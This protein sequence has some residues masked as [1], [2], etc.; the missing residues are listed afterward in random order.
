MILEP[1]EATRKWIAFSAAVTASENV[2]QCAE[3]AGVP[4]LKW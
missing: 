4:P 2:V 1:P 3:S